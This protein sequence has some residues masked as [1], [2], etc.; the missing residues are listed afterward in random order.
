MGK[1]K[2]ADCP[3]EGW[4]DATLGGMADDIK[5]IKQDVKEGF[6]DHNNRL[7]KN[8]VKIAYVFGGL[9]LLGIAVALVRFL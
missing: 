4:A 8:E 1:T 3:F 9:G 6:K 5:E 2:H 7:R